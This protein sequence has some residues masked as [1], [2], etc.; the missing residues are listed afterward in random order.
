[1][2]TLNEKNKIEND[3]L[4]RRLPTVTIGIPAY[5]EEENIT[6]LIEDIFLQTQSTFVLE[7]VIVVSDGSSDGTVDRVRSLGNDVVEIVDDHARKGVAAR[8]NELM[9][10]CQSDIF[11][12]LNADT[13]LIGKHFLSNIIRPIQEDAF[14][15]VSGDL[16]PVQPRTYMER[17]LEAGFLFKKFLFNGY[18]HGDNIYTCYGPARA[19][20]KR[21]YKTIRFTESVGEDAYSYLYCL[22]KGFRYTHASL[23]RIHFKLPETYRDHVLQSRRF[24]DSKQKFYD[25]FGKEF[26]DREYSFPIR[27][28]MVGTLVRSISFLMYLAVYCFVVLWVRYAPFKKMSESGAWTHVASS[29]RLRGNVENKY[30]NMKQGKKFTVASLTITVRRLLY[31]IFSWTDI[32]LNK[33]HIAKPRVIILCYHSIGSDDW[34][35]TVSQEN[36]Y[37][38]IKWLIENKYVFLTLEDIDAVLSGH[39]KLEKSGVFVTFDDGYQDVMLVKDWLSHHSIRP[40][41]FVLSRPD[42]AVQSE[43]CRDRKFITTSE[44]QDL[45]KNGWNIGCH[46]ATHADFSIMTDVSSV[47]PEIVDAREELEKNLGNK[48]M[49]FAYPKGYYSDMIKKCVVESGYSLAFSMDDGLLS[50]ATDRL[51]IPRIGVDNSHNLTD[52]KGMISVS[53]VL[54][55]GLVKQ[56]VPQKLL[57]RLLGI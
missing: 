16:V 5:N 22:S 38:Q 57:N 15:L 1:M 31:H 14:D 25:S 54:F 47:R 55:R 7:K 34:R 43:V 36:F 18:K 13:S 3:S 56:I 28:I 27:S 37:Q 11:V 8:Q 9:E 42:D 33:L 10:I 45:A 52:F 19:F 2:N 40:T 20:S 24:F 21:L 6:Y 32:V 23:A 12:L 30:D 26:V 51:A 17:V 46:G 48:V 49:A 41:I 4:L 53:A 39:K 35:F 44:L 29:K 50:E